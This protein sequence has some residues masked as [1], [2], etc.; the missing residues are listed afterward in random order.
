MY[1]MEGMDPAMFGATGGETLVLN[2]NNKLVQYVLENPEGEN[3]EL[4]AAHI[5]DLA[6]LSN[7]PM[8]AESMT[9]F[10]ARSNEILDENLNLSIITLSLLV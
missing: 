7:K 5:Y 4:I 1:N 10:I 3:S 8:D 2:G 9:K 6:Q